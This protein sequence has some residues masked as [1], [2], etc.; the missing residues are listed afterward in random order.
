MFEDFLSIDTNTIVLILI[1]TLILFL[2]IKHFLFGRVNKV[3]EQRQSDVEK[4]YSDADGAMK[5]AKDL[6]K[7]YQG[8]MSEAKNES[9]EIVKNA[10]RKAQQRSDEIIETAKKEA[11]GVLARANNEIERERLKTMSEMKTQVSDLA[12]MMAEK[13]I[14]KEINRDEHEALINDFIENAGDD[15]WQEK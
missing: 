4:I 9:A 7:S 3:L 5:H 8:M 11:T 2:A 14:Q 10:T 6:E 1:N 15:L 12:V 13:I